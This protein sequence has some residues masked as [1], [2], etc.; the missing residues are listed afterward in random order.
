MAEVTFAAPSSAWEE[1]IASYRQEFL[2]RGDSMDGTAH[3][4]EFNTVEEWLCE[5]ARNSREQTVR[6]GYVVGSTYLAVRDARLV[7]ILSIRH[8]LNGRLLLMGGHIGYSVRPDERRKGYAT[9]MLRMALP[10]CRDEL[11]L[12]RVLVTCSKDNAASAKVI[13]HNAGV[14]E[15]EIEFEGRVIRRYWIAL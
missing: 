15:N 8:R 13:E 14:F 11:K 3:L 4:G 1:Q 12:H 6:E 2:T 7:G 9:G 5:L 10:V